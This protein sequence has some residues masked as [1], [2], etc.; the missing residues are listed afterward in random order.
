MV[1]QTFK[2]LHLFENIN[3]KKGG[4]GMFCSLHPHTN[5]TV[6]KDNGIFSYA[7]TAEGGR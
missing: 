4:Y 6:I 1:C 5:G 2:V 3:E 7:G